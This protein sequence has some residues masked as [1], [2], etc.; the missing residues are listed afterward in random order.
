MPVDGSALLRQDD[1]HAKTPYSRNVSCVKIR[2]E[3]SSRMQLLLLRLIAG[4]LLW[5]VT[6]S[7][8]VGFASFAFLEMPSRTNL[9]ISMQM[10]GTAVCFLWL[11]MRSANPASCVQASPIPAFYVALFLRRVGMMKLTDEVKISTVL[12]FVW[13]ATAVQ[14]LAFL[15]CARYRI[16]V[17]QYFPVSVITGYNGGVGLLIFNAAISM[18]SGINPMEDTSS[19][20]TRGPLM[21]TLPGLALALV[22]YALSLTRACSGPSFKVM[23]LLTVIGVFYLALYLTG[24]PVTL[25]REKSLIFPYYGKSNPLDAMQA[26]DFWSVDWQVLRHVG[27][28]LI[29]PMVF[30]SAIAQ[31]A[32][33]GAIL[34]QATD[35]VK[36]S[37]AETRHLGWASVFSGCVGAM[38]NLCGM[39]PSA[40]LLA[41][42]GKEGTHG[43]CLVI[44]GLLHA[45]LFVSGF[46]LISYLPKCSIAGCLLLP[47]ALRM[48]QGALFDSLASRTLS[49]YAVIWL[50]SVA[51]LVSGIQTGL[52]LGFVVNAFKLLVEHASLEVIDR[53][54]SLCT[55]RTTRDHDAPARAVLDR[56][57]HEVLALRLK[58]AVFF[59]N[60]VRLKAVLNSLF[61]G[62]GEKSH[63]G[64]NDCND[65]EANV[66]SVAHCDDMSTHVAHLSQVR[67]PKFV[68]VDFSNVAHV[69][70]S[71]WATL[72]GVAKVVDGVANTDL[73][74]CGMSDHLICEVSRQGDHVLR[75]LPLQFSRASYLQ[76]MEHLER[77]ILDFHSLEHRA[78]SAEVGHRLRD[79]DF[80]KHFAAWLCSSLPASGIPER[81]SAK[82]PTYFELRTCSRGEFVERE[83]QRRK[84]FYWVESGEFHVFSAD[85]KQSPARSDKALLYRKLAH[86]SIAGA[87]IFTDQSAVSATSL[88]CKRPGQLIQLPYERFVA[89][90]SEDPELCTT[91]LL[92][93]AK[94]REALLQQLVHYQFEPE[95]IDVE[96]G[97][98]C[99]VP[100]TL[101]SQKCIEEKRLSTRPSLLRSLM[102]DSV[103]K[104]ARTTARLWLDGEAAQVPTFPPMFALLA[105][106][107]WLSKD[108]GIREDN[109]P[110][111]PRAA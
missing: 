2:G 27:L 102:F 47:T 67:P 72:A 89:L 14:G 9:A 48:I 71:S 34:I 100:T 82:L 63:T 23:P 13:I 96:G 54:E 64:T 81:A 32:S 43:S 79:S 75:R 62:V 42:V 65:I 70:S 84:A 50:I 60:C 20:F 111:S 93:V 49:D 69:D 98:R 61:E 58:G 55:I 78:C 4:I 97:A 74:F 73:I 41:V 88:Q 101:D 21:L 15:L 66:S 12:A 103:Q 56:H 36:D 52:Y 31:Y 59:G 57:G 28:P 108:D 46:P 18:L 106:C 5:L 26:F 77:E 30:I 99:R 16:S 39:A 107:G 25:A 11:G 110:S 8:A 105:I 38:P 85:S 29:A 24:T 35:S 104:K 33:L 76:T 86:S 80:F 17:L 53:W 51:T 45:A 87:E 109:S 40:M 22:V 7:L 92:A 6:L 83:G 95:E 1:A 10:L 91:L 44:C 68:V 3:S 94:K 37:D 90:R 19:F